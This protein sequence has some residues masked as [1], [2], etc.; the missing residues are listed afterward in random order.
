MVR[1]APSCHPLFPPHAPTPALQLW[2]RVCFPTS[3][4][5]RPQA[6]PVRLRG[7][8]GPPQSGWNP[9]CP[10][11]GSPSLSSHR[12]LSPAAASNPTLAQ[13]SSIGGDLG[14]A[15]PALLMPAAA[16]H[17]SRP[18]SWGWLCAG[19]TH[20]VWEVPATRSHLVHKEG[21]LES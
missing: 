2:G 20:K 18:G 11:P 3:H 17:L 12:P 4:L 6:P 21:L 14:A 5:C 15:P 7:S 10:S 16:P 19:L 13:L 1:K 8:A 9:P